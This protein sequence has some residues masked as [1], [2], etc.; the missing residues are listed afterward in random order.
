MTTERTIITIGIVMAIDIV[1][2]TVHAIISILDATVVMT[3]FDTTRIVV[4]NIDTMT[5]VTTCYTG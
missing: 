2:V 5:I 3:A 1:V 4:A